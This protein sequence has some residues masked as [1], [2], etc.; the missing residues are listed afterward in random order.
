[1]DPGCLRFEQ[2]TRCELCQRDVPRRLITLHHLLPKQKGGKAD[3]RTPLCRPCHKQIH[4]TFSNTE[5]AQRYTTL[6]AI[7]TDPLMGPF[8]KWISRQSPDRNF[9]TAMSTAHPGDKRR[10]L[11]ERR[12]MR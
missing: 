8:L 9:H 11:R 3:H 2:V 6:E 1:M 4:A 10:R 7:R 12:R 5:L